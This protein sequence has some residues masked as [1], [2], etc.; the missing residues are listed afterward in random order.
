M[1]QTRRLR[2]GFHFQDKS[3][4]QLNLT[5]FTAHNTMQKYHSRLCF[6]A[7]LTTAGLTVVSTDVIIHVILWKNRKAAFRRPFVSLNGWIPPHRKLSS[8]CMPR[9][10][11]SG[12]LGHKAWIHYTPPMLWLQPAQ[13]LDYPLSSP[14]QHQPR[15]EALWVP[16]ER[17]SVIFPEAA[18]GWPFP[19]ALQRQ[20]QHW[21]FPGQQGPP[22]PARAHRQTWYLSWQAEPRAPAQTDPLL[23]HTDIPKSP[24][25]P[26]EKGRHHVWF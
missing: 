20:T 16:K 15:S 8:P 23:L 1:E 24:P 19:L 13:G 22:L 26:Q 5:W 2:G 21:P 9:A 25:S 12:V 11:C 14:L 6:Q 4:P 3:T 17:C 10:T 18:V 7:T